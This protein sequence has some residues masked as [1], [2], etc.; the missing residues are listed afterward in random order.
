MWK[1]FNNTINLPNET[2][3]VLY[4]GLTGCIIFESDRCHFT[5]VNGSFVTGIYHL[6]D[7]KEYWDETIY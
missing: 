6:M 4:N 3:V 5:L 1:S 7:I 2:S